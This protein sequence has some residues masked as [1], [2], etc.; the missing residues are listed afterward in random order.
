MTLITQQD[1][2]KD[3]ESTADLLRALQESLS[4]LRR[5]AVALKQKIDSGEPQDLA[6]GA[7]EIAAV[8]QLARNCMKTEVSLAE[9]CNRKAG[10]VRGGYALD[11]DVARA[12]IGCRLGRL[13]TC[14]GKG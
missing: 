1:L 11:L 8:D 10:I 12:E 3:T 7:K 6:A 2:T 14:C 13:R 5:T 9:I 4:D